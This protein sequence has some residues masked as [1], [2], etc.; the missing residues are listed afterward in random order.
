MAVAHSESERDRTLISALDMHAL[1]AI[2]VSLYRRLLPVMW[3][4]T[5]SLLQ[6]LRSSTLD[7]LSPSR[8][9]KVADICIEHTTTARSEGRK[10]SFTARSSNVSSVHSY[11][12]S[13]R[14][15]TAGTSSTSSRS[16]EETSLSTT[17]LGEYLVSRCTPV[18]IVRVD[19]K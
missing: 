11:S 13:S 14:I 15:Q 19:P 2:G 3:R 10:E 1:S 9:S 5:T 7:G 8:E 16:S 6:P 12:I 18:L 17:C 4:A